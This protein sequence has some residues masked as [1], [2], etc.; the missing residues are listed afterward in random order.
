MAENSSGFYNKATLWTLAIAAVLGLL[1]TVTLGLKLRRQHALTRAKLTAHVQEEALRVGDMVPPFHAFDL[2]GDP[3][4]FQA[5]DSARFLGIV[6]PGCL[7]C[8]D[9]VSEWWP[10]LTSD[11]RLAS[12]SPAMLSLS[13]RTDVLTHFGPEARHGTFLADP[14]EGLRE[15][16]GD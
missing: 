5:G 15:Y 7:I 9:L 12:L 8:G 1:F 6:S 10:R 2:N 4:S 3:K 16:L 11:P 14:P 13:T